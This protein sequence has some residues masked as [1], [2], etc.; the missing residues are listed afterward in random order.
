MS[1]ENPL[2]NASARSCR[3]YITFAVTFA[4]S[5]LPEKRH[6]IFQTEEEIRNLPKS[7]TFLSEIY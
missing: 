5:T 2:G 1:F 6:I 3:Y 7:S 4:N